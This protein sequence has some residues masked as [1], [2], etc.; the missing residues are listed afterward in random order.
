LIAGP[1]AGPEGSLLDEARQG[2]FDV[3]IVESLRRAVHPF[4]DWRARSELTRL[5]RQIRP[6]VVH[7]HSS[8]AGILGRLA[9][10][11]AG[12][13]VI[14]HTIHGM[15]FNRTQSWPVRTLYRRLE[16]W[17]S[18]FTDR[19]V[20]VADAMT[21]QAIA[22]GLSPR[23]GFTTVYSAMATDWF[24]P[25]R[26]DRAAVRREWRVG[27][28]HVVVGAIAR[29]FRNKGYEQLIPAMAEA[30]RSN[31]RLRY[32]WIGD[33]VKRADYEG[34]L[35]QLGIR[36]RVHLAGLVE[37]REVARLIAGMDLLVHA[38]QWEGLPRAAVQALLMEKPVVS[39][40]IDGAPEVVIPDRTGI[41]VPLN[42]VPALAA[43][44][45]ELAG[46]PTRREAL[47]RAGRSLCLT[48]FDARAMVER[49][50]GI[51]GELTQSKR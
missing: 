31:P 26:H 14:V 47:G 10:R 5:M 30:A 28:E 20:S 8:K 45:V 46:N 15:S 27:D 7:T 4:S 11:D 16:V 9:A 2:R 44:I 39:F 6:D 35:R 18:G 48:R 50:E 21:R 36:D 22:A 41:L 38:S 37:P 1:E 51:Y 29:L 40:D 43:A 24:S 19:I 33:G 13:P 32:V 34:R 49:L 17:C 23:T 3:R 42:D 12:V 25:Q